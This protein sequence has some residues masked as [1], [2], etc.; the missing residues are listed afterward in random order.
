MSPLKSM[1]SYETEELD[2]HRTDYRNKI[3]YSVYRCPELIQKTSS[4]KCKLTHIKVKSPAG[5]RL[6]RLE[7]SATW[8]QRTHETVLEVL[9]CA[10]IHLR[11]SLEFEKIIYF[12]INVSL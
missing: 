11:Q 2:Q 3:Q 1:M 5:C 7:T 10:K 9:K 4:A 12:P 8:D 6:T